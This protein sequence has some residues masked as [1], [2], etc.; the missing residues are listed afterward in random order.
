MTLPQT[1]ATPAAVQALRALADASYST[2]EV[3]SYLTQEARD[4]LAA[5][6]A[7]A[8]YSEDEA[9]V[10]AAQLCHEAGLG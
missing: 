10:L 6:A 4:A 5:V 3:L 2:P 8:T 7:L 1:A 9:A